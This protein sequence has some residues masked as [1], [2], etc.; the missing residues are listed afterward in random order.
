MEH[1]FSVGTRLS[2]GERVLTAQEYPGGRLDWYDFESNPEVML[3]GANDGVIAAHTR[4]I[5]PAP[6]SYRGMPSTRFW[7]LEDAAVNLDAV[8]AA[9]TDLVRMLLVEF[10]LAY[11]NDW[12]VL[13]I[14]LDVGTLCETQS[15]VITDTFGVKMLVE[16]KTERTLPRS[17]WRMFQLSFTRSS[18]IATPQSNTFF[19]PPALAKTVDGKPIEDV[20]FLKDEMANLA[21]AVERRV[22]SPTGAPLDRYEEYLTR[23][24]GA[25]EASPPASQMLRYRLAND[26][27]EYWV[28]LLPVRVGDGLRLQRGAVLKADGSQTVVRSRGRILESGQAL[29]IFEEEVPRSGVRV[30]RR[31][32]L[33]RWTDGSTHVWI[34][35][36][37][38][39][40]GGEGSSGL[41]FDSLLESTR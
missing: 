9:P 4:T 33:A 24:D 26:V 12:F 20:L 1:A 6:V 25:A 13:P 41:Q 15:L 11:G 19:L 27:P 14:E 10:T 3:G 23:R 35:R 22:E 38:S 17:Q 29:S 37:K 34:G 2:D 31:Y 5:I 36:D 18:G 8:D 32:Q 28:P 40:G 16:P 30:T 7:E 39:I 21:W